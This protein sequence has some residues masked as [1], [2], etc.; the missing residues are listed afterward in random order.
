MLVEQTMRRVWVNS[1]F[2]LFPVDI[3]YRVLDFTNRNIHKLTET[4][5]QITYSN[6]TC[7]RNIEV[8]VLDEGMVIFI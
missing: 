3:G 1:E 4:G 2:V 8:M 7:M 5:W 6:K